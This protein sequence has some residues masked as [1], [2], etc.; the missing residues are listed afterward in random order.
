MNDTPPTDDQGDDLEELY[1][2]S[3]GRYSSRPS[4]KA[5][6]AILEYSARLA[7][8]HS[9]ARASGPHWRRPVLF[10]S[11]AAA[12]LAC[13]LIGPQFLR[14]RA[15]PVI[16]P[17]VRSESAASV[18]PPEAPAPMMQTAPSAA[19]AARATPNQVA[20]AASARMAISSMQARQAPYAQSA[21]AAAPVDARDSVGR[22]ALM[23]A[24]LQGRL[25]TVVALLGRGADPNVAD[26]AGVTPLQAA[27][28]QHQPEIVDAL[29]R[30][31][32]R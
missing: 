11:L 32:A 23:L 24:V 16:Q 10:G 15:P 9:P 30:A 25:D 27:R 4:A 31:G 5:R 22:T 2:K 12:A 28:A 7:R 3:S 13:L 19:A 29:L 6:Q 14:L 1:R 26:T 20:A 21:A 17:T 8:T 18:P